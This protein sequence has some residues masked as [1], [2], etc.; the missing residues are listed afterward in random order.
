MILLRLPVL[1]VLILFSGAA[2][3]DLGESIPTSNVLDFTITRNGD[4]I[5][6]HHVRFTDNGDEVI[7]RTDINIRVT[8]AFITLYDYQHEATEIWRDGVLQ[9]IEAKT[10]NDGAPEFVSLQREAGRLVGDSTRGKLDL[11]GDTGATS[12]WNPVYLD[13]GTWLDTQDG[14]I[15]KMNHD[16]KGEEPV[17][18]QGQAVTARQSLS[19]ADNGSEVRLWYADKR[20]MKMQFRAFDGSILE[21]DRL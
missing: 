3:A 10:N 16:Q 17:T 19:V 14:E 13:A 9:S 15:L 11:P 5:G 1:L 21:Y 12:Y 7:V 18:V 4:V 20:L 8:F 6:A 2:L